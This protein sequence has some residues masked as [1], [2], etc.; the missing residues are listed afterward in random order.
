MTGNDVQIRR[1]VAG[2][3][4]VVREMRLQAMLDTPEAFGSSYDREL[5][6]TEADWRRWLSPGATFIA[7]AG[8]VPRGIVAG[9]HDTVDEHVV[10][11]MAMW[12]APSLRGTG[13]S[14]RLVSAVVAWGQSEGA[15]AIRL[16]V[17][18][19][20][21]RARRLYERCG[22]RQTGHETR[23]ENDGRVEVRMERAL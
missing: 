15:R 3:E 22:F 16:D 14:D 4:P 9:V 17:M 13:A 23:R 12:L 18:K 8:G 11:L 21:E 2:D 6:R 7:D 5:G 20:N 19:A 1:A 10:H